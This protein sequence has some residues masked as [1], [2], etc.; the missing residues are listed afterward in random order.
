MRIIAI[1]I[2]FYLSQ[3]LSAFAI[4][5]F[6]HI[7]SIFGGHHDSSKKAIFYNPISLE[8]KKKINSIAANYLRQPHYDYAFFGMR[9]GAADYEIL[10]QLDIVKSYG[11]PTTSRKIFYPKKLRKR[12]FKKAK[13]NA[14]RV[15][16]FEGTKRR[17][18]E[19]D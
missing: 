17:K 6:N 8:Q 15:D 14:W 7:Y 1:I 11:I 3:S 16:Q 2:F 4:H 19:N 10:A 12:L 5:S 18:W 9:C 13:I